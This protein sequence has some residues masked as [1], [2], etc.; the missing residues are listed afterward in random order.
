M[1]TISGGGIT[2]GF[3]RNALE[4]YLTINP[5]VETVDDLMLRVFSSGLISRENQS[6]CEVSASLLNDGDLFIA[7]KA[8]V[9]SEDYC[10]MLAQ[11]LENVINDPP[12]MRNSSSTP[13]LTPLPQVLQC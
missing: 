11:R 3:D 2:I 7:L 13:V 4:E 5:S 12:S 8:M 6:H 1:V 9:R 10:M